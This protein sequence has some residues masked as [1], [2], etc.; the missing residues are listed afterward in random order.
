SKASVAPMRTGDSTG[1][2][3]IGRSVS[4]TRRPAASTPYRVPAAASPA[5]AAAIVATRSG[6]PVTSVPYMTTTPTAR[7]ASMARSC[8]A[9][10]AAFPRKMPAGSRPDRRSASRPPSA[11]SIVKARWMAS[12]AQNR[13]VTQKSPALARPRNPRSGSRAT[14]KRL[15]TSTAKGKTCCIV[16]WERSSI[17]RSLPATRPASRNKRHLLRAHPAATRGRFGAGGPAGQGDDPVGQRLGPLQ[18]VGGEEHGG[19]GVDGAL[20][21]VVEQL[22]PVVVQPGVGLVEQPQLGPAGD[23]AGQGGAAPLPGG[24]GGHRDVAQA[25]V[26]PAAGEGGGDVGGVGAGGTAPEAH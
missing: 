19:T 26:E 5:V 6:T 13:T 17:R 3:R 15:R 9:M 20:H 10:A 25:A 8:T 14:P 18:V 12:R 22:A 24:Q 1:R 7:T 4:R 2:S 23:E 21:E 16:T 11:D